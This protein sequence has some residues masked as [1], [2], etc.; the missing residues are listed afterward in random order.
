MAIIVC[1]AGML[2]LN[3]QD[4]SIVTT[5]YYITSFLR[6]FTC[7]LLLFIPVI[8]I[9]QISDSRFRHISTNQGL[10]NST[11]NCIFQDSRGFMWFGTR[12]GLNL[13]DGVKMTVYKNEPGNKA[14]LNDNF[15][16]CIYE[17]ARHYLWIG[18]R[19]SL[20]KFDPVSRSFTRYD[21]KA[22]VNAIT[23]SD[24]DNMWIATQGK[25]I[26]LLNTK[27]GSTKTFKHED[28]NAGSLSC[29]S[30]NCFLSR[31]SKQAVCRHTKWIE[32]L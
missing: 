12:D 4:P 18:T 2:Y 10:S 28:T 31:P 32:C 29:D 11:I 8:S 6:K 15:I 14:S 5:I 13:Y 24:A 25:G 19:Y 17:D 22:A 23:G 7:L 26:V 9:A 27:T 16:N 3:D 20:N 21:L 1:C 30:V